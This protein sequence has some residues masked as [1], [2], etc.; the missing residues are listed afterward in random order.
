MRVIIR[1]KTP[2]SFLGNKAISKIER[3][4]VLKNPNRKKYQYSDLLA[5]PLNTAY[6]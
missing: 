1:L 3:Q 4:T 2:F 5:L 6:F